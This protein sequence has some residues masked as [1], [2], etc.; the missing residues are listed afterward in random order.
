MNS[1]LV[2]SVKDL[3]LVIL[4]G[5]LVTLFVYVILILRRTLKIVK[6][7]NQLVDDNRSSI[8]NTLS[9]VPELTKNIEMIS[10]E[11]AHDVGAFRETVDNIADTTQSVTG[12]IRENQGFMS[13]LGSIMHTVA[14]GKALYNRY[15]GDRIDDLKTTV[16][17][18]DEVIRNAEAE[19]GSS[20]HTLRNKVKKSAARK[21]TPPVDLEAHLDASEDTCTE[22]VDKTS[23]PL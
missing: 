8:D 16:S 19:S 9:V 17:D 3:L 5:S 22:A 18:V 14:I 11:V 23:N 21:Q 15:F 2:F 1:Q 13:G 10:S 12:A 7:V 6:Q 20:A 4:W